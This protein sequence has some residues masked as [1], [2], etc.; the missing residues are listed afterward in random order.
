MAIPSD[1]RVHIDVDAGRASHARCRLLC[2]LAPSGRGSDGFDAMRV[3]IDG[4]DRAFGNAEVRTAIVLGRE[5]RYAYV[6]ESYRDIRP[7]VAMVGNTYRDVFPEAAAAGAEAN[8]QR[9]LATGRSWVVDDYPT[10]LPNRDVPAWWQGECVPVA[11]RGD[12]PDAVLILIWDVT[13]RHLPG[14]GPAAAS[15]EQTRVQTARAKLA[16]QMAAMGLS[17][18]DGWQIGEE[19]RETAEGTVWIL[20]PL[21]M[22]EEAP[23]LEAR[24]LFE[25]ARGA[26]K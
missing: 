3:S 24:V 11:L 12:D 8:L 22:R 7:D 5:L 21:H 2:Q 25:R 19:V 20:R 15:R 17:V 1:T 23:P 18:A 10:P 16:A 26:A 13:R 4:L 14:I 6:N 9:T